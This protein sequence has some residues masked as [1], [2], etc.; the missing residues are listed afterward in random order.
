MVRRKLGQHFLVDH[1]VVQRELHY[2]TLSPRDCVLE[3]GAGHGAL[4]YALAQQA[5]SVIAVEID[6]ILVLEL[7]KNL[8]SNVQLIQNDILKLDLSTLPRFNKI[9]ANLP[10]HIS[11]PFTF[12]IIQYPFE[13]AIFIYQK[14]FARRMVA[15]PGT[16]EYSRLTVG[17]YYACLCR[18]LEV[19]PKRCFSPQPKVDCCIVELVPRQKP[20]FSLKNEAFFF[21]LTRQL[22]S[23]RRKKIKTILEQKYCFTPNVAFLDERVENITPEQIAELSDILWDVQFKNK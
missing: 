19:V 17:I 10:F 15:H 21:E 12:K 13:K 14:D 16:K 4:T 23:Y 8:P 2:A 3:I 18:I 7:Q 9:V 5:G 22:F 20:A 6:P 11:S 1:N